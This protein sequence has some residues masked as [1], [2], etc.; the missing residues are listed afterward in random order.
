M[1]L[2]NLEPL[3]QTQRQVFPSFYLAFCLLATDLIFIGIHCIW[4]LIPSIS[5]YNLSIE[6]DQGYAEVFQYVKLFWIVLNFIS[7]CY[8]EIRR[9]YLTWAALFTYL[10]FDDSLSLHESVG[11]G[12][13]TVLPFE[14]AIYLSANDVGELL[15]SLTA[16]LIFAASFIAVYRK[17][18]KQFKRDSRNL[19]LMLVALAF[20]GIGVDMVHA[21]FAHIPGELGDK[22]FNLAGILEDGGE[23]VVISVICYYSFA[24][25]LKFNRSPVPLKIRT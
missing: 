20:L 9:S 6:A 11:A 19:F 16:F 23:M 12:I 1:R 14:S 5:N 22:L 24:R 7:I 10:L 17:S 2:L 13:A 3:T 18:S 15:V 8:F 4:L 25:L 21:G